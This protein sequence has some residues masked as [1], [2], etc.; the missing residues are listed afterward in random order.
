MNI[1]FSSVKSIN[2]IVDWVKNL[3][4]FLIKYDQFSEDGKHIDLAK[5]GYH[6]LTSLDIKSEGFVSSG[7]EISIYF[8]D[9]DL[10]KAFYIEVRN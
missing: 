3:N 4:D 10:E 2:V 9:P 5:E 7:L 1:V 8:H 6:K